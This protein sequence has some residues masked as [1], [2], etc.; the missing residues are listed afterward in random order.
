MY[1]FRTNILK[2]LILGLLASF[3]ILICTGMKLPAWVLFIGWSSQAVFC[4]QPKYILSILLQETVGMFLGFLIVVISHAFDNEHYGLL[5]AVFSIVAS[6]YWVSVL[7]HFNN[8]VAYF[9]GMIVWFGFQSNSL[10][11]IPLLFITLLLG[12]CLGFIFSLMNSKI[13]TRFTRE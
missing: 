8:I 1:K 9:M 6:L 13:E 4:S 7:K 10:K 2:S 12:F 5:V 11:D 3:S